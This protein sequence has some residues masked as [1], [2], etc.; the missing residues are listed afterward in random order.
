MKKII[1]INL[2]FLLSILCST[3]S[4]GQNYKFKRI[5]STYVFDKAK[6]HFQSVE[7][8]KLEETQA[9]VHT[10]FFID[11]CVDKDLVNEN[12]K[13][14][15]AN[16]I[17]KLQK[18]LISPSELYIEMDGV[19]LGGILTLKGYNFAMNYFHLSHGKYLKDYESLKS[20]ARVKNSIYAVENTWTNYDI[21]KS[22]IDKK[23]DKWK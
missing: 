11:W 15:F 18:R 23:F 12:F 17:E 6:Y 13:K 16:Q 10:A 1:K 14:D 5:D 7:S 19:F 20:L 8:D 21:V 9:F 3:L 2:L 4:I 22:M